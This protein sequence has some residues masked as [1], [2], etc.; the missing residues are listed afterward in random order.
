VMV[1]DAGH[2]KSVEPL[3]PVPPSEALALP[4]TVRTDNVRAH[5]DMNIVHP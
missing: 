5:A 3:L 4:I 2:K 1:V